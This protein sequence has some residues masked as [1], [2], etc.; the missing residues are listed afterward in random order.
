MVKSTESIQEIPLPL[1]NPQN[2]FVTFSTSQ[3]NLV[4]DPAP[5]QLRDV[6]ITGNLQHAELHI[7]LAKQT[8]YNIS[9]NTTQDSLTLILTQVVLTAPLQVATTKKTI[10]NQVTAAPATDGSALILH[11][12]VLPGTRVQGW[13]F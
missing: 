12:A 11:L 9:S 2:D 6:Y 5:I 7:D 10:I 13:L 1:P 3:N 4:A 8:L